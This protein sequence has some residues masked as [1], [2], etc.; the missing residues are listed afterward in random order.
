M[1]APLLKVLNPHQLLGPVER[2]LLHLHLRVA[3][4]VEQSGISLIL[5]RHLIEQGGPVVLPLRGDDLD[6]EPLPREVIL[7]P[8]LLSGEGPGLHRGGE[9]LEVPRGVADL[10]LLRG[11]GGLGAEIPREEAGQGQQGGAGHTLDLQ[12]LGADPV[13]EHQLEGAGL[14]QE[15]LSDAGLDPEHLLGAGHGLE[16]QLAGAGLD[17]ELLLG[18]DLGPGH[19]FEGG[20]E[21]DLQPGE[22]AG[23]ALEHQ[24]G[25]GGQ[26]LEHQ[27]EEDALALEHL[28]GEGGQGLEHQ[29]DADLAAEVLLDVEDHTLEHQEEEDLVHH[30]RGRTNLEHLR[31]G[32]D[33]TQAQK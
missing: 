15:H 2:F 18:A 26:D 21:V 7:G 13:L 8:G 31:G 1:P 12:P 14:D 5:I 20:L 17:L 10:G 32:A 27:L 16:H 19:Q 11:Q 24:P 9:N 29:H 33:P 28:P 25:E 6:L 22:V 3:H 30:Q 23:H 4:M